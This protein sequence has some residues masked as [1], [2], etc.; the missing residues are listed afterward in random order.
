MSEKR[1]VFASIRRY[2][3]DFFEGFRTVNAEKATGIIEYEISELENIFALLL[4]G[5]FIG[6][7]SP[8]AHITLQLLPC[9]EKELINMFE[10]IQTAHDPLGELAE[11]LGEF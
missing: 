9:M 5:S 10:K 11:T 8:P 2:L 3:H 4:F 7:P 1:D 6:L